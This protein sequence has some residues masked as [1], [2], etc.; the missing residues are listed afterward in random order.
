LDQFVKFVTRLVGYEMK[1]LRFPAGQGSELF[2]E[3]CQASKEDK[4]RL[5][6]LLNDRQDRPSAP[7]AHH[8]RHGTT[9]DEGQV[10]LARSFGHGVTVELKV[11]PCP[12][13]EKRVVLAHIVQV[14]YAYSHRFL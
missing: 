10:N 1:P 14:V 2:G 12:G 8:I 9:A 13:E 3:G 11:P 4:A 6:Q 5:W 7:A